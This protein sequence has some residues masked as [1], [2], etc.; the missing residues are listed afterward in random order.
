[1]SIAHLIV[2]LAG[3]FVATAW[4][5]LGLGASIW[6]ILLAYVAAGTVVSAASIVVALIVATLC[7]MQGEGA[8]RVLKHDA[9]S[10]AADRRR[11]AA[12]TSLWTV[13]TRP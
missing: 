7:P 1:M 4:V 3:S 11:Q 6:W 9:A 12:P 10:N 13:R 5:W 8:N 2:G